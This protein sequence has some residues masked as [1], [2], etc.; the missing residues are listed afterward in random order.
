MKDLYLGLLSMQERTSTV[1]PRPI[2]SARIPPGAAA[3]A[4]GFFLTRKVIQFYNYSTGNTE[5]CLC[6]L[7]L[8]CF[9]IDLHRRKQIMSHLEVFL[10]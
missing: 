2:S 1:L 3:I 5:C 6:I 7:K 8:Y 10:M 4:R 9:Q